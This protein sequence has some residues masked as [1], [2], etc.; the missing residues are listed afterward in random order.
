MNMNMNSVEAANTNG[1]GAYYYPT[2][3]K[4]SHAGGG[5]SS[6]SGAAPTPAA[7]TKPSLSTPSL[8]GLRYDTGAYQSDLRQSVGPGQYV[9]APLAPHCRPCLASDTRISQGTSGQSSCAD[10]PLIDVESDLHNLNRRATLDPNGLYRGG[11]GPPL[12]CGGAAGSPASQLVASSACASIP[13]VDT[14]LANPPCTLRGTGWNRWE[15]LCQDPQAT[16]LRPFDW[17]IDTSIV[18]KDNHRPVLA[19]PVDPTLALPPGKNDS[20]SVG[21][22]QWIPQLCNGVGAVDEPPNMLWRSCDEVDRIS[23]GCAAS[24]KA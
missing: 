5:S 7:S 22:P 24:A 21:S 16:A 8:S 9:L 15:W 10:Q 6:C 2:P 18:V 4:A 19:R 11:G 13:T 1:G 14:R 3:Q 12:V 17:N 20:A 23:F